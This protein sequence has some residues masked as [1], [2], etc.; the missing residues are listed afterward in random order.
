MVKAVRGGMGVRATARRFKVSHGTVKT[1]VERARGKRLERV[2]FS[3][4]SSGPHKPANRTSKRLEAKILK[5]R[6]EL[7]LK[8]AL[9]EHG[10][11]AILLALCASTQKPVPCARTIGRILGRNGQLDARQRKRFP[12][13]PKGWYLP[14]VAE[15]KVELDSFDVVED[16]KI[17]GGPLVC[18]LT[19]VSLWGGQVAAWP[20]ESVSSNFIVVKMQEHWQ[21]N[22]LPGY[23]QFDNDTRFQGTHRVAGSYG[24]VIR[25]CLQAGVTPVFAPP[26]ETGFQA[27]VES[28]NGKW[29]EKVWA[30]FKHGSL[31]ELRR[32]SERYLEAHKERTATRREQAPEREKLAEGFELDLSKALSGRVIYIRRTDGEG[33]VNVA[34]RRCKTAGHWQNRLVR[35]EVDFDAEQIR[36]YALRRKAP[37]AQPLLKKCAWKRPEKVFRG[38]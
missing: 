8:S 5:L 24:R 31:A 7:K 18:V 34:G 32:C 17:E 35:C 2:D 29:Q 37:E 22:G 11:A 10:A 26:R 3:D 23:A 4:R 6:G 33:V 12:A 19:G 16:L 14:D 30:R 27:A 36:I 38:D 20:A 13:P 9:G 25:M 1:W 21:K 28:H 15:N